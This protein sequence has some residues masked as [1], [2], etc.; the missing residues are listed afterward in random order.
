MGGGG[1]GGAIRGPRG[2]E[3][4]VVKRRARGLGPGSGRQPACRRWC[5]RSPGRTSPPFFCAAG[6][7]SARIARPRN[8][9]CRRNDV[10]A[11]TTAPSRGLRGRGGRLEARSPAAGPAVGRRPHAAEL[12]TTLWR[13]ARWK[14]WPSTI[15][16]SGLLREILN[17]TQESCSG[18]KEQVSVVISLRNSAAGERLKASSH[19]EL[20]THT[21]NKIAKYPY[22][23]CNELSFGLKDLAASLIS[24][25]RIL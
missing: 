25:L 5:K 4:A 12:G 10:A 16:V 15:A 17:F 22:V 20:E 9:G 14:A 23:Y 18:V 6:L 21:T 11:P 8:R 13:Q 24:S 7:T 3:P 1:G 2:E 19:T